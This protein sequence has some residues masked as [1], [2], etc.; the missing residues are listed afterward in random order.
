[1]HKRCDNIFVPKSFT[2]IALSKHTLLLTRQIKQNT[3]KL[4]PRSFS[5]PVP[6]ANR[7]PTYPA[8]SGK[9]K[10]GRAPLFR[11]RAA[12]TLGENMRAHGAKMAEARKRSTCSNAIFWRNCGKT[13]AFLV[14]AGSARCDT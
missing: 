1:M 14:R 12:A 4:L 7:N 11:R 13:A 5:S 6:S 8:V 2:Y 10:S 3:P 9:R